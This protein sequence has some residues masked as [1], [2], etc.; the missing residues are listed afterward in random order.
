[1]RPRADSSPATA[2][3]NDTA[4]R[5]AAL[6]TGA[7]LVSTDFPA[8][9]TGLSYSVAIPGGTPSRCS[10]GAPQGC[11]PEAIEDPAKLAR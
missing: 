7:Q 11:T 3:A 4:G 10:P 6:A 9:V 8:P 2:R 1:V 5:E